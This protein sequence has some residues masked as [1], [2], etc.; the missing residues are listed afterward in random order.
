[1]PNTPLPHQMPRQLP[2]QTTRPTRD[3]HRALGIPPPRHRQHDLPHVLSTAHEPERLTRPP[4]IPRPHRQRLQRTRVEEGEQFL[5]HVVR[6][7]GAGFAE[8]EGAVGDVPADRSRVT[9]IGLAHLQEPAARGRQPQ[10]RVHELTRQSVQHHIDTPATRHPPEL[11]LEARVTRRRDVIVVQTHRPQDIPL[12]LTRGR[13]H[14]R[15]Q[16]TRQPH[17]RHPHTTGAR[18]HQHRL[19][20]TQPREVDESVVGGQE[21]QWHRR[22]LIIGPAVGDPDQEPFVD[23]RLGGESAGDHAHDAVAGPQTGDAGPGRGD[24]TG[25]L[26]TEQP[27]LAGVHVQRVQHVAEVQARGPHLHPHLTPLRA[28]Q[29]VGAG[30]EGEGV[31]VALGRAVHPPRTLVRGQQA[32][33]GHDPVQPAQQHGVLP[34]GELCVP[35][36]EERGKAWKDRLDPGALVQVDQGEAGGVLGV[37]RTHQAPHG[38]PGEVFDPLAPG[39]PDRAA[40]DEHQPRRREPVLGQP[41]LHEGERTCGQRVRGLRHVVAVVA[42]GQ[43]Y[44]DDALVAREAGQGLGGAVRSAE[45]HDGVTGSGARLGR[46][47]RLGGGRPVQAEQGVQFRPAARG[48]L[49]CGG[50]PQHQGVRRQDRGSLEVDGFDGDGVV[51]RAGHAEAHDGGAARVEGHARP[52]EGQQLVFVVEPGEADGLDGRVQERRVHAVVAGVVH[53]GGEGGLDERLVAA[54]PHGP[55]GPEDGAVLGAVVEAVEVHGD[56]AAGRPDARVEADGART[57]AEQTR[58]VLRPGLLRRTGRPGVETDLAAAGLVG[59]A[60]PHLYDGRGVRGQQQRGGEGE[61]LHAVAADLVTGAD[62]QFEEAGGREQHHAAAHGVV[63]EP[64]VRGE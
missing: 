43:R 33:T 39:G 62:G 10:R 44:D 31:E 9:D 14:L 4:H 60:D 36:R 28:L 15:P 22:R 11:L 64:R 58:R 51:A 29:Q 46:L 42:A 37:R 3:Q 7:V 48:R 55:D 45:G 35:G 50:D 47:G 1:M 34:H 12:A 41:R 54:L 61:L 49:D 5:Q 26:G 40:G 27:R 23:Q 17:R 63:R 8:V 16:M 21:H 25:G 59:R 20:R 32:G 18:M 19:T 6:P 53:L 38:R 56:G 24:H 30:H 2:R 52:Q 57:G 13:E